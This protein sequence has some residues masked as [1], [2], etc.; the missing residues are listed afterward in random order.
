MKDQI[1]E[2]LLNFIFV[3]CPWLIIIGFV[4]VGAG[5]FFK[6]INQTRRGHGPKENER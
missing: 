2:Q 1:K 6:S 5:V 3:W 4:L